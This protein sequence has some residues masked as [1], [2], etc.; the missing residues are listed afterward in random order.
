MKASL[1]TL[2]TAVPAISAITT[3]IYVSNAPQKAALPYIVLTQDSSEDFK[4]LDGSTGQLRALDFSIDCFSLTSIGA[5]SLADAVRDYLKDYSGAAGSETIG[6][7]L[8][9]DET[10]GIQAAT[11]GS[12]RHTY[13]VTLSFTIMFN[14]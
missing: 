6:A 2:L 1:V 5:Q 3:R 7:V 13:F 8:L 10:D 4:S 9:T 11:D 14:P 12:D